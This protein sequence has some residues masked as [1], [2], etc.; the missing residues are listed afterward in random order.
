MI[1][2]KI[3]NEYY[4]NNKHVNYSIT[5]ELPLDPEEL[6]KML[7]DLT[8][9][10][11]H[12]YFIADIEPIDDYLELDVLDYDI[13]DILQFN[14]DLLDY[15]EPLETSEYY[16]IL[17]IIEVESCNISQAYELLDE[18]IFYHTQTIKELA[19]ELILETLN[20]ETLLQYIDIYRYIDG[21]MMEYYETCHGVLEYR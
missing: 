15:I 11:S 5:V 8:F 4:Y 19:P 10:N 3:V 17:S 9:N 7:S 14:L 16:H 18:T 6:E 12:D 21:E 20:D 13:K 2:A 1:K